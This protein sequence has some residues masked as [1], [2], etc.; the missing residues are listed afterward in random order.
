M[1]DSIVRLI[2]FAV[3]TDLILTDSGKL[4]EEMDPVNAVV[5]AESE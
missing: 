2:P 1:N 5:P 3:P 4:L